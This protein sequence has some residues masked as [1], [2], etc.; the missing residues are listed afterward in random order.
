M[1]TQNQQQGTNIEPTL[2]MTKQSIAQYINTLAQQYQIPGILL[3]YILQEI[4][5][6]NKL[7]AYKESF[8]EMAVNSNT[9]ELDGTSEEYPSE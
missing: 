8:R 7:A 9:V 6:E 4:I 5:Y 3:I 1:A 2:E